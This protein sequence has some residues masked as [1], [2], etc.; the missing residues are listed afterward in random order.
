MASLQYLVFPFF[1]KVKVK[2]DRLNLQS[3]GAMQM[4]TFEV[5]D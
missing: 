4:R 1:V 3:I 5:V 2:L